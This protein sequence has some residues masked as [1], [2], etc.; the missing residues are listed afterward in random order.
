M[1]DWSRWRRNPRMENAALVLWETNAGREATAQFLQTLGE[2]V[3][4]PKDRA[5]LMQRVG[6][7]INAQ[8]E[9]SYAQGIVEQI[10]T[11]AE[12]RPRGDQ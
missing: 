3:A 12:R 2:V 5:V 4:R 10:T 6:A 7:L 8:H 11:V 1:I 9:A